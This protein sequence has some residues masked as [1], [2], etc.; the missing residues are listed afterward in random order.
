[1]HPRPQSALLS[2]SSG[3]LLVLAAAIL[4]GT[5]GTAQ[6]LAP[7]G[8]AP[9]AVGAM[10][11]AVGGGALVIIA[12][13]RGT[14]RVAHWR[15]PSALV[16]AAAVAA[17]QVSFFAGVAKTGVTVGTLVAIG[18]APIITGVLDML[19]TGRRP[20][21]RWWGATA[22][23][24]VGC[25]LLLGG[26]GTWHA[27]AVGVTL[28]LVAGTA[29]AVYTVASKKLL[30]HVPP[31]AAIATTFFVGALLLSPLLFTADLRWV[32]APRGMVVVLHLGLVATAAAYVL[33]VRGLTAV[34]A[35]TAATL[36]LAEPLTAGLLS[37]GLL[38]ERLTPIGYGGAALLFA[39]LVLLSIAPTENSPSGQCERGTKISAAAASARFTA[40]H[41]S[42][43][44]VASTCGKN[45][46][47][48]PPTA[49]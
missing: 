18:S 20:E 16:A 30:R 24:V 48:R 15:E 9:L 10:R 19:A 5:T 41:P 44:T 13:L 3:T 14:L 11:L 27:D 23:A 45:A 35:A 1:M 43:P 32:T 49:R 39:A 46:R 21:S 12:L 8:A 17:Y 26:D 38:G 37:V 7:P 4:W 36:T 29:F 42:T 25:V 28:A 2:S 22:A 34:S 40:G 6:A 47:R 33:Y 31:D